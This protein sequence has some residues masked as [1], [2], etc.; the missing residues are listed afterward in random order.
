[1]RIIFGIVVSYGPVFSVLIKLPTMD[2]CRKEQ[3]FAM[4]DV[5]H[6]RC[7]SLT[8]DVADLLRE[9]LLSIDSVRQIQEK[10]LRRRDVKAVR[11]SGTV[12]LYSL[13]IFDDWPLL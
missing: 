6:G 9:P 3:L 5:Y 2:K 1:M 4:V 13:L 10:N 8:S 12:S 7:S 11:K